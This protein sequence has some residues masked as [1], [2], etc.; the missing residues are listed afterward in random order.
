MIKE[1]VKNIIVDLGD[2]QKVC[3]E[4]SIAFTKLATELKKLKINRTNHKRKPS[5]Y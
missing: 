1:K 4:I 3:T 2:M 5:K